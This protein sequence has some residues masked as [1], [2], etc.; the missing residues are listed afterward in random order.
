MNASIYIT[1]ALSQIVM[2]RLSDWI[3]SHHCISRT[4]SQKIFQSVA[5]IGAGLCLALV[6]LFGCNVVAIVVVL[7]VSMIFQSLVMGGETLSVVDIAPQHAATIYGF[8]NAVS[9][10][11]GFIAPQVV[12]LLLEQP[13]VN[14]M[15]QWRMMFWVTSGIFALGALIFMFG[16]RSER[17]KWTILDED[18][19]KPQKVHS[20]D[21]E[22][23][24]N[25]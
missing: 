22:E 14:I 15:A 6:P 13:G 19:S 21:V 20:L 3:G 1:Y 24:N 17:E 11:P 9:G 5:C 25:V 16:L 7:N 8:T 10:L 4:V 18:V 2:G 23:N 12:G